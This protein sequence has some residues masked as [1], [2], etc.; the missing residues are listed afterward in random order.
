M[1]FSILHNLGARW[2][3]LLC[4]RLV[5]RLD[6]AVHLQARHGLDVYGMDV[7]ACFESVE[8]PPTRCVP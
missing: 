5:A 1:E 3:C 2:R 6:R 7:I 8:Q 4:K